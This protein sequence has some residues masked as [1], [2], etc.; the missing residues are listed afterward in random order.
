MLAAGRNKAGIA[1]AIVGGG[2]VLLALLGAFAAGTSA[3][4]SQRSPHSRF[5]N[6]PCSKTLPPNVKD[7]RCGFLIAP[8]NHSRPGGRKVRIAVVRIPSVSHHRG[9][10]PIVYFNGGPGSDALAVSA[11][12][13][14]AGLNQDHELIVVAQRGTFGSHP[15]LPCRPIDNFRANS[16]SLKFSAPSTGRRFANAGAK[17]RRRL[18]KRGINLADFNTIQNAADMAA[19]RKALAIKRWDVFSHSYGTE[20]ALT[21][22]RL[23]PKGINSVVLDG[24]VPPSVASL[25]WTW[26]SFREFFSNLLGACRAQ[27]S[28]HDR[29]PH[30]GRTYRRVVNRLEAHPITTRVKVPD[31]KRPA[32]VKID[33]G[34]LVNWLT[35]QS[36]F[37]RTVPLEI[38]QLAH[39]HPRRVAKQW[40]GAR[41]APRAHRGN[42]GYGLAYGVWCSEWVPFESHRQ[43]LRKAKRAFPGFPRSVRAQAP[44]LA[45]LQKLCRR[46]N[47][48][49]APRSI[50]HV[51]HSS[52]PTLAITGTFDAQTGAKWGTYAAKTLPNST[53]VRLPGVSH[54]AFANPCG[55]KVIQSFF[56]NPKAPDTKC[57]SS[58]HPRRFVIGPPL[59]GR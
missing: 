12:L 48:P 28:C 21:Y 25:G 51:T 43:E 58:V 59:H 35:R 31:R 14:D 30:T 24:T 5:V 42:F 2:L 9:A 36:H 34:V 57:V 29:Y 7:A 3:R 33:G 55:A 1:G 40:A 56:N 38:D 53:V 27:K 50:R 10:V 45:F 11:D 44:Q 4:Q 41:A 20:L 23:H 16:L 54:G 8:E 26:G 13:V 6:A 52:V 17:C 39:G 32:N 19:L 18:R 22:M 49:K 15:L 47:V 46:W 37:S